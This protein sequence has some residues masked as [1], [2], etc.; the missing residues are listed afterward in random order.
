MATLFSAIEYRIYVLCVAAAPAANK[1]DASAPQCVPLV[2]SS[3]QAGSMHHTSTLNPPN[4]SPQGCR[5]VRNNQRIKVLTNPSGGSVSKSH[6]PEP[7]GIPLVRQRSALPGSI[8]NALRKDQQQWH[9]E[10]HSSH[11]HT[12]MSALAGGKT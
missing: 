11:P 3:R 2:Q 8:S 6:Q 7:P 1:Q 10:I 12:C 5:I 9:R 4:I